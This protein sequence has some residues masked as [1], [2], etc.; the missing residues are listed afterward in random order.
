MFR[1]IFSYTLKGHILHML[2]LLLLL[3][4]SVPA[5]LQFIR[6]RR[7]SNRNIRNALRKEINK[8]K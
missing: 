6:L 3:S 4:T 8:P 5:Y 1:F 7:K 2:L